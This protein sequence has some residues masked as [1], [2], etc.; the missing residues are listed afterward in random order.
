MSE[1]KTTMVVKAGDDVVIG[2]AVAARVED[3]KKTTVSGRT[4][5]AGTMDQAMM[6]N[7]RT[8]H[9]DG[10]GARAAAVWRRRGDAGRKWAERGKSRRYQ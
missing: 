10:T 7:Q 1:A 9:G 4:F 6:A 3:G 5:T 2:A 8:E